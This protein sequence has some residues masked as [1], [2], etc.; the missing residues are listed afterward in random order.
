GEDA[1]GAE[2]E[3][4]RVPQVAGG[5]VARGRGRIG[6]LDEAGD[7]Q[8]AVRAGAV[9]LEV[10]EAGLGAGGADAE[11]DDGVRAGGGRVGEVRGGG[12]RGLAGDALVGG[13]HADDPFGVGGGDGAR[14]EPHGGGGVAGGRLDEDARVREDLLHRRGVVRAGDDPC[15][16]GAQ[17]AAGGGEEGFGRVGADG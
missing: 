3:D 14:G 17:A 1:R 16:V 11:R 2:E 5:D 15:R 12:D 9:G 7:A 10:A 6:F 13:D 4:A 8:R